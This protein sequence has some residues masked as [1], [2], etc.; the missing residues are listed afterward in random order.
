MLKEDKTF[1]HLGCEIFCNLKSCK[2]ALPLSP[3]KGEEK[4]CPFWAASRNSAN[5]GGRLRPKLW[6]PS[7]DV[8]CVCAV[9]MLA[10]CVVKVLRWK[11]GRMS[12]SGLDC[13]TGRIMGRPSGLSCP[14]LLLLCPAYIYLDM[15]LYE[16]RPGHIYETQLFL[17]TFSVFRTTAFFLSEH[18]SIALTASFPLR[19]VILGM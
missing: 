6:S 4:T 12:S 17:F 18:Y 9:C 8:P 15:L 2:P 10:A 13:P 3:G 5:V 11:S 16:S 14:P 7:R 19:E 1:Q